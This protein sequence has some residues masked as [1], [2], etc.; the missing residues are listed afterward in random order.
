M[1]SCPVRVHIFGD[2]FVGL[3]L[4]YRCLCLS[5]GSVWRSGSVVLGVLHWFQQRR[6]LAHRL[7]YTHQQGELHNFVY[8]EVC[9]GLKVLW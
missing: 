4:R 2:V 5:L 9:V 3:S 7:Q 8:E 1:F 6:K